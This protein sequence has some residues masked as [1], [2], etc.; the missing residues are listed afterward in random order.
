MEDYGREEN[1]SR[2]SF[3]YL[4]DIYNDFPASDEKQSRNVL[5]EV[6]DE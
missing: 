5:S 1:L 2:A 6:I 4:V 3:S